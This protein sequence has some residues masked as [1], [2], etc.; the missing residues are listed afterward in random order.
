MIVSPSPMD[1]ASLRAVKNWL[2][3]GSDANDANLQACLTAASIFFLRMTGRG[4][5][6]WQNVNMSPFN[7]SVPYAEVYDGISGDK[8]FLRN[9]PINAVTSVSVGSTVVQ[10]STGIGLPGY[11]IDDQGRAIAMR[12]GGSGMSPQTFG[13][14]GRFGNGYTAGAGAQW[15]FNAWG[16]GPQ[17]IA[18]NYSAGF[19]SQEIVGDLQQVSSAW[20]ANNDYATNAIVSDGIWLQQALNSGTS[21]ATAPPWSAQSGG[22]T[23]DG[24]GAT[25]I[26]WINLGIALGPNLIK[27]NAEVAFLQDNG[28]SYFSS[29]N[30]LVPVNVAPAQ[31]Q[32]FV[33]S[34]GTYLFNV[35]D[36]GL[37]MLLSYTLAGTPGDIVLA[38]IQLVS[39]NYKRRDWIGLRSV[40]MK[41]VGSTS[42]TLQMDPAIKDVISL[43]TRTSFSS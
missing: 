21:G 36:T 27:V 12:G 19:N 41:D 8:L 1:L 26:T 7:Q 4:P 33:V 25:Q 32:Y 6:N 5:R 29:G 22:T 34:P 20:I 35:A 9:F 28:V 16:A 37:E 30:P 43:Y 17:S 42:Y 24:S 31:G 18:I 15:A 10:P 3:I 38:V 2:Q 23:I 13:Y 40:A 11:V 39:L 14:V